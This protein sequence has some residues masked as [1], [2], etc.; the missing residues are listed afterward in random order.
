MVIPW[1]DAK[2]RAITL[3]VG[4]KLDVV[5]ISSQLTDAEFVAATQS[6]TASAEASSSIPECRDDG[7]WLSETDRG[8]DSARGSA[9]TNIY[10]WMT[11]IKSLPEL[12]TIAGGKRL[13]AS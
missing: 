11:S 1:G 5:K 2:N 13:V 4:G 9:F 6:L 10:Y 12:F 3:D 7:G 8:R